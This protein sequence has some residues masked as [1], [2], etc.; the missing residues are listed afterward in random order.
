VGPPAGGRMYPKWFRPGPNSSDLNVAIFMDVAANVKLVLIDDD[1]G[2]LRALGLL[3]STMH[4][5]VA[6]FSCPLQALEYVRT[7]E[8]IDA[9]LTD[10]R[11]PV[12]S[13]EGV[14]QE[15]KQHRKT[16]PVIVMS[17][18]ASAD[19]VAL[20]RARGA[21]GFIPKPFTPDQL[22]KAVDQV[23]HPQKADGMTSVA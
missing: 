22:I 5:T 6:P 23:L 16:L 17:G 19:E 11:M 10:L 18:H 21:A 1:S 4:Y 12:L 9:V 7:T 3:L 20:L 2:V 14:V 15:V 13:G 8:Q